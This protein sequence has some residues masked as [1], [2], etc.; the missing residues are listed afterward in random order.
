M[1]DPTRATPANPYRPTDAENDLW[2]AVVIGTGMGGATAGY[3]LAQRGWRVLFIEKGH[4]LHG[5][6]NDSASDLSLPSDD[7]PDARLAR[8]W[9]PYPVV[10]VT[11][12]GNQ[13][14]FAPLGCGSGGTSTLYAAQL[15]RFRSEDFRPRA[16]HPLATDS[17]LPGRWPIDYEEL[18]P[19]YEEA[20]KLYR[21]SGTRDP[22]DQASAGASLKEPRPLSERDRAQ[23]QSFQA[24]GLHPY[25]A[26]VACEFVEG[27]T[28]CGGNLCPR[29]CKTDSA[30]ACL[31]PA[32]SDFGAKLLDNCEV[33]ELEADEHTVQG[34]RCR[35]GN[36]EIKVRGRI[37]VLATGAFISPTLLLRSRSLHWPNGL[38]NTSD[39]VGRNL[40][41]HAHAW[42]AVSTK[43]K[44]SPSGPLKS[45]SF[46]DFYVDQEAK[47]GTFQSLGMT[48]DH[49]AIAY[50]LR[51]RISSV[52]KIIQR[53]LKL[54]IR[55][56]AHA[57][58]IPFRNAAI[59]AG[60][61]EDL[62]YSEN[63]IL[64]DGEAQSGLRFEYRYPDELGVRS[65]LFVERLRK[66]LK[67]RHRV[68]PISGKD[69]LDWGHVCGTIRF[70]DDPKTSVLNRDNRAHDITNLYVVDASFLPSSGGTNLSLTIA[71]NALRAG[72]AMDKWLAQN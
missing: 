8:G 70:G 2:D 40:M 35:F 11:T 20:E 51:S 69:N 21:V 7:R 14:F 38:A 26:H 30:R 42:V 46:N 19:Y 52:P 4:F 16:H 58:V 36:R 23:F 1:T 67:G 62:P 41:L 37:V 61:I 56:L 3:A 24:A 66:A 32:L 5:A 6:E 72:A 59:F 57:L 13:R 48:A 33:T 63:R 25:R 27:C 54:P 34:V 31:L 17:S 9:W 64:F 28:G 10:G 45:I 65:Q 47:L 49:G 44:L 22:L 68:M 29:G 15:E 55:L 50:Y 18:V 39:Q 71:A 60:I 12:F 43:Q 53:M